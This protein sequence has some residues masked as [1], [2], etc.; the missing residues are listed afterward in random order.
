MDELIKL[1]GGNIEHAVAVR[2]LSAWVE[3]GVLKELGDGKYRATKSEQEAEETV[4]NHPGTFLLKL[5]V[6][7]RDRLELLYSGRGDG[8]G[9]N[10]CTICGGT[11]SGEDEGV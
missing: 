1:L 10:G 8:R 6:H 4:I 7:D 3:R 9:T 2:A 5:S 11:G